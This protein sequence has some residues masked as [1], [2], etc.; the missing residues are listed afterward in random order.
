M[1]KATVYYF[2]GYNI[3]TDEIIRS[4]RMATLETIERF[5]CAPL[6]DTAREVDVSELDDSGRYPKKR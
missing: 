6:M 5:R 3:V 4:K 1:P 2:T